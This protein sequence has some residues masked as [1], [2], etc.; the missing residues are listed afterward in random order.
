MENSDLR[1]IINDRRS[2]RAGYEGGCVPEPMV[3]AIVTAGLMAPSSKNA[4]PWRLHVV[5]SPAALGEIAERV[6]CARDL[7]TYVPVDPA[8]G[9]PRED[10]GSTVV[11][12]ADVLQQVSLGLFVENLGCF[13]R[14]RRMLSCLD[15]DRIA[16]A[17]VGYTFE[18][19]G[20]GCAIQ[21]MWL[22]AE[23]FG[24]RGVFM[25]D[26]VIAED[27]IGAKL[28]LDGDLVGVLALGYSAAAPWRPRYMEPDR[29]VWH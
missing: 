18:V 2:I 13:S 3:E 14:G 1:R 25:G 7:E 22:T 4:Q 24:L 15:G 23:S 9:L 17:L 28:G 21:N 29:V 8:T 16:K 10:Y 11:E 27:W 5:Q 6:R 26:I 19:V 12:S 20:I